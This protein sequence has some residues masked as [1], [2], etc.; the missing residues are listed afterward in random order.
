MAEKVA[1]MQNAAPVSPEKFARIP[2]EDKSA[3]FMARPKITYWSDAWRRFKQNKLALVSMAILLVI[4]LMVIIVPIVSPHDFSKGNFRNKHAAASAE[5]WFGTDQLGRDIFTRI[6]VGGRVSIAIGLVGALISAV[7]GTIYGAISAFAGGR[8]D[9]LMMRIIEILGSIPYLLLVILIQVYFQERSLG[10][11][12][13][14]L[15]IT[16][17]LGSARMVRG[18]L[19]SLKNQDF[20]LAAR[21][22]GVSSWKTITRHLIPNTLN[23]III[24]ITFDIPGYIFS[25][26]FLSYLG[27]GIESPMTSWGAMASAAQ[28]KFLFY[29]MELFY[30]SLMIALTMLTFVLMGDGLR[31]AL[32]PRLRE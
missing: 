19:L 29:P 1:S 14:A 18:Q 31:D 30:P 20:V 7:V 16:G 2:Q 8:V 22:L 23:I 4:V 17:W 6:F 10:T 21:T 27:I 9:N 3:D 13:L 32:D 25:E 24:Q 11:M 5:H 28:Q 26:A 12:I 15:T